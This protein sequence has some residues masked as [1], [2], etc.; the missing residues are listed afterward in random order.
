MIFLSDTPPLLYRI[1][2]RLNFE[3][4]LMNIDWLKVHEK[5]INAIFPKQW[6]SV[7]D[8]SIRSICL[9]M[10]GMGIECDSLEELNCIV[11]YLEVIGVVEREGSKVRGNPESIFVVH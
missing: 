11:H 6:T 9:R 8:I 10:K 1:E 5:A 4:T 2:A 3:K 7:G